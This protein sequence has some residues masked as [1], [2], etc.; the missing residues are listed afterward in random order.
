MDTNSGLRGID[1]RRDPLP[2]WGLV[3]LLALVSASVQAQ[4]DRRQAW[5]ERLP[6]RFAA[7]DRDGDGRLTRDEAR[8]RMP[9]VYQ[10]FDALD[11]ANRG[12][13]TLDDLRQAA[14]RAG[15]RGR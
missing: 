8:S 9:G 12:W 14:G 7:A 15:D 10:R 6:E 1:C 11:R 4:G 5:L 13:L 3:S 2:A